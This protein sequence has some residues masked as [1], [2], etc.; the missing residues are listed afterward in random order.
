MISTWI[1]TKRTI[2]TNQ[3][4]RAA[5]TKY[6]KLDGLNRNLLFHGS[7]VCDICNQ[8]VDEFGCF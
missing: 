7:K 8:G 2:L 6:Q 3:F 4:A 5:I 1:S